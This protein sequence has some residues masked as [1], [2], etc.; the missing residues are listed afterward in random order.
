MAKLNPKIASK[1]ININL[2]QNKEVNPN[3]PDWQFN[4]Y[5]PTY[6][7]LDMN[8]SLKKGSFIQ[9][10]VQWEANETFYI[11]F[12]EIPLNIKSMKAAEEFVKLVNAGLSKNIANAV[13][14][15]LKQTKYDANKFLSALTE[16]INANIILISL[17]PSCQDDVI[18]GYVR[19]IFYVY[20][21]YPN[22]FFENMYS[23]VSKYNEYNYTKLQ[24]EI[25]EEDFQL[26]YDNIVSSNLKMYKLL[27]KIESFDDYLL[28]VGVPQDDINAYAQE[29][30]E[31]ENNTGNKK[32]T[33][34]TTTNSNITP[35]LIGVGIIAL[36]IYL[37]KRRK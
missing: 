32:G 15:Y 12:L 30:A 6:Q 5:L 17:S 8:Q 19:K 33:G 28:S 14:K 31:K 29:E 11:D 9:K 1:Q 18:L 34:K 13:T 27:P 36:V 4:A 16:C 24:K 7:V 26:I 21:K 25:D 10:L 22:S 3:I 20:M 35:L 37:K 23:I 2:N